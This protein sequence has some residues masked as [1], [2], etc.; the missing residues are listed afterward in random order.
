MDASFR[1][2]VEWP[3]GSRL[4]VRLAR[5]AT[6]GDLLN[7]LSF[8]CDQDQQVK[9]VHNGTSIDPARQLCEQRIPQNSTIKILHLCTEIDDPV[10]TFRSEVLRLSD[11]QFN[12]VEG[13][14]NGG[15]FYRSILGDLFDGD[16]IALEQP[17][18]V[19]PQR[20]TAVADHPLPPLLRSSDSEDEWAD[21][22][23]SVRQADERENSLFHPDGFEREWDW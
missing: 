8:C 18:T 2:F 11:V 5:T 10:E 6:G 15:Q 13:H 1:L 14:R 16:G 23:D 3:N 7:L 22:P 20:A 12:L 4:P 21:R 19:V 17:R 9:F